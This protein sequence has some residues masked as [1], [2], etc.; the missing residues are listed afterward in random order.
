MPVENHLHNAGADLSGHT[1]DFVLPDN[2]DFLSQREVLS[3]PLFA[4]ENCKIF[5]ARELQIDLSLFLL[6]FELGVDPDVTLLDEI[7][8]RN[9]LVLRS[10]ANKDSLLF[11]RVLTIEDV[12]VLLHRILLNTLTDSIGAALSC[13][14]CRGASRKI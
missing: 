13:H 1:I 7:L 8:V 3:Q 6:R 11:F 4:I 2:D 10:V 12:R 14:F 9:E 5:L